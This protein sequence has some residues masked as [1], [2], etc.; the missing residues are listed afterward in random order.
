MTLMNDENNDQAG[1]KSQDSVSGAPNSNTAKPRGRLRSCNPT[2]TPGYLEVVFIA[3]IAAA[4]A[5]YGYDHYFASKI[6]VMD[7]KGYLREQKALL[8][9]GEITEEQWKA[10]LDKLGQVLD[11][12]PANQ[13]ILLKE[14]VLKNGRELSIK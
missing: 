7:I 10:G 2:A 12:Q 4:G 13:I 1:I 9:A 8:V 3:L 14:V 5:I 11:K 6:V